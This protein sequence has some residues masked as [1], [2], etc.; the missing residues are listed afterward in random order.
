MIKGGRDQFAG[1]RVLLLQGPIGPFFSWLSRDLRELGAHV[2][3]V[4]FNGGDWLF[5]PCGSISF[6]GTSNEWPNFLR[7]LLRRYKI[8][9][10][11]LFGDCRSLH[12]VA[13]E[14][15]RQN[16][17]RI[18]VFEEGYIR[19][20]F[21]TFEQYGV[22]GYS[23]I[24]R[25]AD[26]YRDVILKEKPIIPVGNTFW[27]GALWC[28][29]Y[30]VASALLETS[31]PHYQHHRPLTVLEALPW[32]R[33]LGRKVY[34]S[35]KERGMLKYLLSKKYFFV[36]LQVY[37]DVQIS[38]HSTFKSIP[39]FIVYVLD[40][41][42]HNA[43]PQYYLVIKHHPMDRA[44]NEYGKFIQTQAQLLGIEKRVIY[45]HDQH[46]PTLLHHACGVVLVNST[47]GLSA[48]YHGTPVKVCGTA[49][50]DLEGLT[51]Q[52]PLNQFWK[53][54]VSAKPNK[55]LYDR[56]RSYLIEHTQING[57]FYKRLPKKNIFDNM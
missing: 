15:A 9:I 29:F 44:Y 21:I 52:G 14:I 49:I 35:I 4:D 34:Y 2:W 22:N 26:F 25:S 10:I 46:L 28:V 55:E 6:T 50:Y 3:K 16:S 45:I 19:P 39:E 53:L 30:Y 5:S 1:Q 32:I 11:I 57:S 54:A 27:Y 56:L 47:V 12:R 20:D 43:D 18:G 7:I 13:C 48:L 42:A 40:S 36:P 41:F 17:I 23:Q 38:I 31:F 24:P 8:D 37:N 51:F 33:S